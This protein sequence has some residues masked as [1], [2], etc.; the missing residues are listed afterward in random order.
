ME[1]MIAALVIAFVWWLWRSRQ[2]DK[3]TLLPYE[4][5]LHRYW[6][7][8]TPLV[9]SRMAVAFLTQSLHAALAMGVINQAQ[10]SI[11]KTAVKRQGASNA[12][13]SWTSTLQPSVAQAVGERELS[14]L[15]ARLVG[16]LMV[17][18][19]LAPDHGRE[20]AIRRCLHS[21]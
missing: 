9:R 4:V 15:A 13:L 8:D 21:R 16:S 1:Y 20:E 12:V 6:S 5:W 7:A 17:V 11:I 3:Q 10:M 2:Y 19:L 18:A 14:Y